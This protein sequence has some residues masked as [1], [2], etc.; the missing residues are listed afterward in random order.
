MNV[1]LPTQHE[2]IL[3][4]PEIWL[5]VGMCAVILVPF[6]CRSS[7]NLPVATALGA[8]VLALLSALPFD[9]MTHGPGEFVF[10]NALA[11][12]PFSQFFKVLLY[13]FTS[14]I[15]A[16]WLLTSR[17]ETDTKDVPDFLCL[18]LGATLGMSLM[19]S[20]ANLLT[21][22]LAM[23]AASLPSFALAG[24]RKRH[25]LSTE[26]S[27]K[28]VLFGAAASSVGVY[29]MSLIYASS[30]SLDLSAVAGYAAANG[31]SPL[32][33]AGLAAMF[34]GV[35][36][37]LSAAPLHLWCPDVFEGAPIEVTTFL[38]VA[39]KGAAVCLLLR[40][41]AAFGAAGAAASSPEHAVSFTGLATGVA[42]LGAA[43][44]TWGNLVALHQT[45]IKR[46]LAYSSIAHSGYMIMGCS[47]VALVG[48][49]EAARSMGGAILLYLL[50]YMFMNLGAFAVVALVAQ[51]AGTEQ[52]RDYVGMIRSSPAMAIVFTLF[53]LSL[54]GMPP[55]GGFMG[56]WYL[57]LA[58]YDVGGSVAAALI[59][60][61]LFNTVLSA[62]YYFRPMIY[63]VLSDPK[64]TKP[65]AVT[66][67]GAWLGL[68]TICAVVL[69]LT[70]ILP[71]P[72]ATLTKD[73]G[74]IASRP[75]PAAAPQAAVVESKPLSRNADHGG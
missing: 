24:F 55:L 59:A 16:L 48:E 21:I 72:V 63:M 74:T 22:F 19:A 39:S 43:T 18:L 50:I 23:E 28:Y 3:V 53:L 14:F 40:I 38:S 70:F 37:K 65:P 64:D 66:P 52:V 15:I 26:G 45:N 1:E 57:G 75:A 73:Y 42:L 29:G 69:L 60:V 6:I 10:H 62:Y 41:V 56:K 9:Q 27:L 11:I 34:A 4:M 71:N 17:R 2:L 61:L 58:M 7:V 49:G 25:R 20:A 36:F 35:A 8:L 47:L 54:L 32:M 67:R 12:D 31:I 33:A 51:Q 44:A 68:T 13:V 30:G 46:L 5:A